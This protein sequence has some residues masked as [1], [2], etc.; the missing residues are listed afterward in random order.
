ARKPLVVARSSRFADRVATMFPGTELVA[1]S[2]P[3]LR[4]YIRALRPHQWAK[5]ALL[6]LP[7]IAGHHFAGATIAAT[8][9]AFF[10][11]CCAASGT[12]IINDLLDLPAD[13]EH[14]DKRRRPFAAGEI[15][16]AHGLSLACGTIIA[17]FAAALLLPIQFFGVLAL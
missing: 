11:F 6:F 8:L 2:R 17:A 3:S 10:C 4:S 1:T 5:N 7:L 16:I 13:R 14:A 15:P 12:Y 9:L